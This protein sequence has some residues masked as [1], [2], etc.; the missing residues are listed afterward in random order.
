MR[1]RVPARRSAGTE[2]HDIGSACAGP[3][4]A[5]A[6]VDGLDS[7]QRGER[8]C[9]QIVPP[10]RGIQEVPLQRRRRRV[11]SRDS[12]TLGCRENTPRRDGV[13]EM[14]RR[15]PCCSRAQ[16]PRAF[17]RRSASFGIGSP[18]PMDISGG[19]A[20]TDPRRSDNR[21]ANTADAAGYSIQREGR[22]TP[23]ERPTDLPRRPKR[24]VRPARACAKN[25]FCS[26]VSPRITRSMPR[27]R[28]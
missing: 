21:V 3:T 12:W 20:E 16:S 14:A 13:V 26:R 2:Q 8:A 5:A 6:L 28:A 9:G 27:C 22:T 7:Q 4:G 24:S 23:W 10:R 1:R 19:Q 18:P 17:D 25:R 11:R 15:S